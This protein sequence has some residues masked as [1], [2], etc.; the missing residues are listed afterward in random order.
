MVIND[1]PY[2]IDVCESDSEYNDDIFKDATQC[3][4]IT[5]K[6]DPITNERSIK[7][8]T[9]AGNTAPLSSIESK[10]TQPFN[11]TSDFQAIDTQQRQREQRQ[12]QC[13]IDRENQWEGKNVKSDSANNQT[14]LVLVSLCTPEAAHTFVNDLHGRPFTSLQKDVVA[15]VYRVSRLEEIGEYLKRV[16]FTEIQTD[17]QAPIP[18]TSSSDKI[19]NSTCNDKAQG[20]CLNQTVD[21]LI[22]DSFIE[23]LSFRAPLSSSAHGRL[24]SGFESHCK[25][26]DDFLDNNILN[27]DSPNSDKIC[28]SFDVTNEHNVKNKKQ[29]VLQNPNKSPDIL[30]S[31][32]LSGAKILNQDQLSPSLA[33]LAHPSTEVQNCPVCLERMELPPIYL[34][35]SNMQSTLTPN[36]IS[37]FHTTVSNSHMNSTTINKIKNSMQMEENVPSLIGSVL[38]T[39]S[40]IFTTVCNHS[41]HVDCLLRC[42]DSPCPVCRY[43]HAGLNDTLTQCHVCGT[44]ENIYVCLICG[45]GLCGSTS[46]E[47]DDIQFLHRHQNSEIL[48]DT[49]STLVSVNPTIF[50]EDKRINAKNNLSLHLKPDERSSMIDEEENIP[51]I[52]GH[53]RQHYED[54]LHAY[55]LD[56]SRQHVWDFAGNGFVHRLVQADGK[57][58]EVNDPT[59]TSH[60]RTINPGFTDA[61][62]EG[63]VHRKLEDYASQYS[64]LLKS[65]L[66]QQKFYYERR[67]ELIRQDH[68]RGRVEKLI[69]NRTTRHNKKEAR[70]GTTLN[71]IK[72]LKQE[73]NQLQQRFDSFRNKK[74]MTLEDL[75]FLKNMNESLEANKIESKLTILSLQ[76]DRGVTKEIIQKNL[77]PLEDKVKIL[78]LQLENDFE[79]GSDL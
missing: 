27:R 76:K 7:E 15:S 48:H 65:Q 63:F 37:K 56:T 46:D 57:I 50:K 22:P 53:A 64:T 34:E 61:Q 35:K 21:N 31:L 40:P 19:S 14:Y 41:F 62:E 67:L 1:L 4:A 20:L 5:G 36:P 24:Y 8:M 12:T 79:K 58:V 28:P 11:N 43:D 59:N 78:M 60:E 13:K 47:S 32:K 26:N 44:T 73:R 72:A 30:R 29:F 68:K 71:F 69:S 45:V 33:Y 16:D 77:A 54:T 52:N 42:Q 70:N 74:N 55:V 49:T 2:P 39:I 38:S 75:T 3:T 18:K 23:K 66:E 51:S 10:S 17:D 6:N 9:W 25:I